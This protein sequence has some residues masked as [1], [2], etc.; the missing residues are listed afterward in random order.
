MEGFRSIVRDAPFGQLLRYAT[1]NRVLKY[2]EELED[3]QC[4]HGYDKSDGKQQGPADTSTTLTTPAPDNEADLEKVA[5]NTGDLEK[6]DTA[7]DLEKVQ[8]HVRPA[9]SSSSSPD[10]DGSATPRSELQ[11]HHTL[12]YTQER[13]AEDVAL[14]KTR[15]APHAFAPTKT[16][17]GLILVDW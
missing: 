12:P 7:P 4:P 16:A 11:R 17:D 10:I 6:V 5:S 1:N 13:L 3:F 9:S 15:S 14:H 8:S 2:P